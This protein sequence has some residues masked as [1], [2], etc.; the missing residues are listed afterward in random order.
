MLAGLFVFAAVDANVSP[1]HGQCR[2]H[3]DQ[4]ATTR[5]DPRYPALQQAVDAYFAERRQ[6]EGFTGVSV[7]VTSLSA[8]KPALHITRQHIIAGWSAILSGHAVQDCQYHQKLQL[9]IDT[10]GGRRRYSATVAA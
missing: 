6:A 9:R 7:L 8:E 3:Q 2:N 4:L 5:S 10:A 1:A